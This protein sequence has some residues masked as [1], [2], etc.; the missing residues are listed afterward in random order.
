MRPLGL[1]TLFV[2]AVFLGGALLAPWLH[3]LIQGLSPYGDVFQ[4]MASQPFHRYV[5]RSMLFVTLVGLWPF[6]KTLGVR[7]WR[8]V[9]MV[10][11]AG[12]WSRLGWGFM[13]GLGSLALVVVG[14]ALGGAWSIS[15]DHPIPTWISRLATAAVAAGVV[16]LMEEVVFR[17]GVYGALRKT[18]PWIAAV[19]LSGAFFGLLHFFRKP[20]SPSEIEWTSGFVILGRMFAGFTDWDALIP[21]FFNV[22][23]VGMLLA[24]A[25]QRTG[26]LYFSIGLHTGWV[27]W[28]KL[29]GFVCVPEKAYNRW[30]WGSQSLT[31]G[32]FA[33]LALFA[34]GLVLWWRP[35]AVGGTESR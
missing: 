22:A 8:D 3:A 21:G 34:V 17:G 35:K 30:I 23:L 10:P 20:V 11:P 25:Y 27:F 14:G 13:L 24:W 2:A 1:I 15:L 32:W 6:L 4:K 12:Q 29:F 33:V 31:D 18:M 5:H 16:A 28:L 7:S 26:N 9:G 19:L